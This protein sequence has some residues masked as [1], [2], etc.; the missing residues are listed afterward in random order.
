M[1]T[2]KW[3]T[4]PSLEDSLQHASWRLSPE[5]A[6]AEDLQVLAR[7]GRAVQSYGNLLVSH[8]GLELARAGAY[9]IYVSI[10]AIAA[11]RQLAVNDALTQFLPNKPLSKEHID[12]IPV[13]PEVEQWIAEEERY[14]DFRFW[15][16]ANMTIRTL[17]KFMSSLSGAFCRLLMLVLN[18][19]TQM[20]SNPG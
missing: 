9:L 20:R 14:E 2:L 17:T 12:N 1:E 11:G 6:A 19:M 4:D 7:Q 10:A 16:I 5:N 18:R 13:A 8:G 15:L 3:Y